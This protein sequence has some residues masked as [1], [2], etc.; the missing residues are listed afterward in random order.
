M[1]STNISTIQEQH[2]SKTSSLSDILTL[3]LYTLIWVLSYFTVASSISL[4]WVPEHLALS[5]T[6]IFSPS[7][8][9]WFSAKSEEKEP[10]TKMRLSVK[11]CVSD[12]LPDE[13]SR[14]SEPFW[15]TPGVNTVSSPHQYP[16]FHL[17]IDVDSYKL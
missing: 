6:C 1:M 11:L 9:G 17:S 2:A 10:L 16:M 13:K 8:R 15:F 3:P 5:C 7:G 12:L 4:A 14:N